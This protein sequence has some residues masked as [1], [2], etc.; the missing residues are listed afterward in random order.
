VIGC[1]AHLPHLVIGRWPGCLPL[2]STLCRSS[3]PGHYR[4]TEDGNAR[5][6]DGVVERAAYNNAAW[7]DTVCSTH[8]GPG[9]FARDHW[10]SRHGVPE[11][12]PD[13]VTLTG[14]EDVSRQTGTLAALM[15]DAPGRSLS[16]KDSF[17]CLNLGAL[18][19]APLFDAEWLLASE[20][21]PHGSEEAA[22]VEWVSINDDADLARWEQAWRPSAGS[23]KPRLFRPDLLSKPG[24]NFVYGL[25]KDAPVGGGV[26][27][28]AGGVTG[29]S[30]M[31]TSGI[32][33]EVVLQ[34]LARMAWARHPALPLVGYE[35]GAD[36]EAARRVGFG[37]VGR[38]RVWHRAVYSTQ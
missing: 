15:R 8:F 35:S 22:D 30:N 21:G 27:A 24:I 36:L 38:L 31:F 17:D 18:G 4:P 3:P 16:V 12:Y 25:I 1:P 5:V 20:L 14:V 23:G 33:T 13:L 28:T 9:E 37:T 11:Y 34:G 32:A 19:F 7:C 29:L 10:L 2:D 26:L 6:T